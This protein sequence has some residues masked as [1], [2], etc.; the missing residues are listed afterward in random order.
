MEGRITWRGDVADTVDRIDQWDRAGATHVSVSTMGAGL[1][2]VEDH[3]RALAAVR[4][5]RGP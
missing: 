2:G 4:E 1:A 3:L 5:R